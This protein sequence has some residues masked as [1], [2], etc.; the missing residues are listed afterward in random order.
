MAVMAA[1]AMAFVVAMMVSA[2]VCTGRS[3][4]DEGATATSTDSAAI[5]TC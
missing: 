1:L 4:A 2:T 3:R 5:R